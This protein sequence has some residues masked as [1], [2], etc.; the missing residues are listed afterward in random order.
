M[1]K[2]LTL[3]RLLKLWGKIVSDS[4]HKGKIIQLFQHVSVFFF[5]QVKYFAFARNVYEKF[6]I[7]EKMSTHGKK[8]REVDLKRQVRQL[9]HKRKKKCIFNHSVESI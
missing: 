9:F 5:I 6:K 1:E 7:I 2:Y 3:R 4:V 8:V